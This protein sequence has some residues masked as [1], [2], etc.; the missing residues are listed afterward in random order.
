MA[1][2]GIADALKKYVSA[3]GDM[4]LS[5]LFGLVS[6]YAAS[7]TVAIPFNAAEQSALQAVNASYP[8]PPAPVPPVVQ[9]IANTPPGS[10][11]IVPAGYVLPP[12]QPAPAPVV[13]APPPVDPIAVSLTV[14]TFSNPAGGNP[15]KHRALTSPA[16]KQS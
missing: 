5:M 9:S 14:N 12:I 10:V 7:K 4:P 3:S 6:Q 13:Q 15:Q 8:P 1:V 2:L 11:Q 16:K